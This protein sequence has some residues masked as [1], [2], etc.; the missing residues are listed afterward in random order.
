M[1]RLRLT[2]AQRAA[3]ECRDA[4]WAGGECPVM[5]AAW[6]GGGELVFAHEFARDLYAEV[7]DASNAESDHADI[8]RKR[9]DPRQRSVQGV[10]DALTNLAMRILGEAAKVA[11]ATDR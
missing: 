4:W 9:K 8:L 2:E 6:D 3:L 5:A 7:I 10:A 1:I 11:P